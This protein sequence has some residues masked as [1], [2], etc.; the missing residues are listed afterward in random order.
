MR[1]MLENLGIE[2]SSGRPTF[3]TAIPSKKN[4]DA[5]KDH[6]LSA[7]SKAETDDTDFLV[8][9]AKDLEEV[10]K[11]MESVVPSQEGALREAIKYAIGYHGKMY[12]AAAA[13]TGCRAVGG[14][15]IIAIKVGLAVELAHLSS[16]IHDDIIDHDSK[17]RG[18][19]TVQSLW[20][21][22]RA[23]IAGDYL[24]IKA[25]EKLA[26]ASDHTEIDPNRALRGIKLALN[27]GLQMCIGE[28]T[29]ISSWEDMDIKSYLDYAEQKTGVPIQASFST[30]AIFGG[31]SREE[32]AALSRYG[33]G[34]GVAFQIIDDLN[35]LTSD[36]EIS[37][38]PQW[39]D[40]RNGSPTLVL[41]HALSKS[42]RL[43]KRRIVASMGTSTVRDANMA[44]ILDVLRLSGSMEY[45]EKLA[46]VMVEKAKAS[47][48]SVKETPA[49]RL[50]LFL[51]DVALRR[52]C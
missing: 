41:V 30:G 15:R 40:L 43:T 20:G 6:R 46:S 31:G 28:A 17:R 37:G 9:V 51:A 45:A 24:I 3:S 52:S 16:L 13:I 38:K 25:I 18:L 22:E 32:V 39:S 44:E 42:D 29:S 33:L 2:Q 47:L 27:A 26:S 1:Q 4:N 12:R 11:K 36:E 21:T 7:F 48:N 49:K 35:N 5:E 19:P 8:E 23:I 14:Q 10:D 34:I 50:L